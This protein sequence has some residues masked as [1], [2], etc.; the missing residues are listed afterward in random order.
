MAGYGHPPKD[1]QYKPGQS[2][3]PSGRPKAR[4]TIAD[5]IWVELDAMAPGHEISNRQMIARRLVERGVMN[6]DTKA[7][8]LII[9]LTQQHRTA[10]ESDVLDEVDEE[11]IGRF[12]RS[13][14]APAD[15]KEQVLLP[16]P[17]SESEEH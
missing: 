10:G 6:G 4:R 12:G 13:D 15:Q 2:G 7:I 1:Y 3:N 16:G 14:P 9:M 5:D 8:A 11:I 17:K